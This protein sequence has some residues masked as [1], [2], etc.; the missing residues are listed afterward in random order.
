MFYYKLF[1]CPQS[2]SFFLVFMTFMF[3]S[4]IFF[5][6]AKLYIVTMYFFMQEVKLLKQQL[7]LCHRQ[8]EGKY[9]AIEILQLQV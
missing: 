2:V 9:Q 6:Y 1:K 4:C 3:S 5:T 7:E 8:L